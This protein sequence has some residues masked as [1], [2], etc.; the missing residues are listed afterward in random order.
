LLFEQSLLEVVLQRAVGFRCLVG[1][2]QANDD[3]DIGR[4]DVRAGSLRERPGEIPWRQATGQVD[5]LAPRPYVTQQRQQ[6]PLASLG[7]GR[8]R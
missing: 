4:T 7:R 1:Q 8:N 5:P 2:R 6:R 3:V